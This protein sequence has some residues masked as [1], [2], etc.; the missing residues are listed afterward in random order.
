MIFY[1]I[2]NNQLSFAGDVKRVGFDKTNAMYIPDDYLEDGE[3]IVMRTCHGIGDW[4]IISAL[5]RLLKE[6]Y[7]NCKVYVPSSKMLKS[8]FGDMMKTWG[9]GVYDSSN[10]SYDVFQ[11]NPYVDKFI[12]ESTDEIFHDHYR[13]Y[14]VKNSEIPL[15]TQMLRFWQFKDSELL[16]TTPDIYFSEEEQHYGKLFINEL[17]EYG[18]V[19]VS[20]TYGNTADTQL[21]VDK[22]KEYGDMTWMYYGENPIEE[23]N[24]SFIKNVINIKPKRLSLRQQMYLRYNARV[25]VGNESGTTLWCSKYSDTYVL[26]N[27]N[28]GPLHGKHLDGKPR[29]DPFKSG[30]FVERINYMN[31]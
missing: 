5:P 4:C 9:Y 16:D 29:K 2:H 1:R 13:I 24:L 14:D 20:S 8:I 17:S 30:N 18:Y 31:K 12:D 23:T 22:I 25:N 27:K 21:L 28:Y 26:G 15:V 10:V 6:K 3:F 19:G 11:N 7:P